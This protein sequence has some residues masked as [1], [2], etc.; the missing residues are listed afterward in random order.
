MRQSG[1][2]IPRSLYTLD[3]ISPLTQTKHETPERNLI[4]AILARAICDLLNNR[5]NDVI[6]KERSREWIFYHGNEHFSFNYICKH[7][8]LDPDELRHL[9]TEWEENKTEFKF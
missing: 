4:S 7:L 9:I 2:S 1:S 5:I 6:W 3:E 8:D